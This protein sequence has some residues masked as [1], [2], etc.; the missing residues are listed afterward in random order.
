MSDAGRGPLLVATLV[1]TPTWTDEDRHEVAQL[2]RP[3]GSARADSDELYMHRGPF[4]ISIDSHRRLLGMAICVDRLQDEAAQLLTQVFER[5][6]HRAASFDEEADQIR[7][8]IESDSETW[9]ARFDSLIADP[10]DDR[11]CVDAAA[12]AIRALTAE[13]SSEGRMT[14]IQMSTFRGQAAE[15]LA[16]HMVSDG[17]DLT[18]AAVDEDG[19]FAM[20]RE[21]SLYFGTVHLEPR[22]A[23]AADAVVGAVVPLL[24]NFG[25]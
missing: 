24:A 1:R 5:V 18:S 2:F 19:F 15:N 23:P 21:G 14:M 7:S 12:T 6:R 13:L 9:L 20:Q 3:L 8:E 16:T 25:Q 22:D 11:L 4:V 10:A 17:R